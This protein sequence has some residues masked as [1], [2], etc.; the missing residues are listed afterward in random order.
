MKISDS[1]NQHLEQFKSAPFLF[2]GSGLSKRYIGL[3]K[4]KEL[5]K[6]F[7]LDNM[8][9]FEYY[10]SMSNSNLPKTATLMSEDFAEIW[11]SSPEF[12][13]S[14]NNYIK[15]GDM[16]NKASPLKY[17]ISRYLEQKNKIKSSKIA[18]EIENLKDV[19]IDG[20]ITTNWDNFLEEIFADYDVFVGQKDLINSTIHEIGELYKIHGSI[21]DFNSLILTD[22]DYQGFNDKNPYLA[23]KLL[24]I[25]IEHPIIFLGYSISDQNIKDI[26][27]LLSDCMTKESLRKIEDNIILVE[28]VFDD[29]D[30]FI[31]K[32]YLD[33]DK[34]NLP[35]THIKVKDYSEIYIP[36]Q[37]YKRKYSVKLLKQIKSELYK[38]VK[39]N[40]PNSRI[41]LMDIDENTDFKDVDFVLGVG[42]KDLHKKGLIGIGRDEIIEDI[43]FD[44]KDYNPK[45][46]IEI[47]LPNVL[48]YQ[49]RTPFNK[50][51]NE[52]ELTYL[53]IEQREDIHNRIKKNLLRITKELE[54]HSVN[55]IIKTKKDINYKYNLKDVNILKAKIVVEG[56]ESVDVDKLHN[57]LV[58]KFEDYTN[59]KLKSVLLS[60]FRTITRIY[61]WI[62]YSIE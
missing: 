57:L 59:E 51:L 56:K 7:C 23:A 33:I 30:D 37:N 2:V 52:L 17:E 58:S 39:E 60:N 29:K 46:I 41:G 28:P 19:V 62:N 4:W 45:D 55:K 48:K 44:N 50:Y 5:L 36:L 15:K 34:I 47:S 3:P 40:D 10:K 14:R 32:R 9:E 54:T 53:D 38:I 35:I 61:D 31:E 49:Y 43:I 24:S 27:K 26:L 20:V 13:K 16:I 25:F 21:S 1:L 22:K 12:K 8:K 11:W 42:I 6:K 18:R